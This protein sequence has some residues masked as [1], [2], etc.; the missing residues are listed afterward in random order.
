MTARDIRYQGAIVA[1][2]HILLI[3][4]REH[5]SGQSYWLFPGG[6]RED[7]E[8]EEACICREMREETNLDVTVQR[9]LL[10]LQDMPGSVYQR[11]KTY[12]CAVLSGIAAPG[13]EPEEEAAAEYGIVEV[14]W[15]DL[16]SEAAWHE[17]IKTDPITYPQMLRVQ[18]AL[19]YR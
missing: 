19:G 13:Y 17:L 2:H 10:D 3:R 9:L 15:F 1:D 7:G 6:G 8:T 16:R 5:S 12:L 14:G 4:H 18:A 11:H